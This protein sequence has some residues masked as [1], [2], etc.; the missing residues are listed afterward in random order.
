LTQSPHLYRTL[1]LPAPTPPNRIVVSPVCQY[2]AVD[3]VPQDWQVQHLGG[4]AASGRGL[5]MVE[6]SGVEAIG[7]IAPCCTGI[8][9]DDC[10]HEF[11]RIVRLIKQIGIAH[12]GMQLAHAGRKAAAP[13]AWL[14]GEPPSTDGP[15]AWPSR[16]ATS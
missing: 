4:F 6:A 11:A 16:S 8:C 2:S 14:G 15:Q 13:P 9:S 5:V 1:M 12:I 3:G 10:E 7:R